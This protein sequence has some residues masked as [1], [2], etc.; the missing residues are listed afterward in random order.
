MTE[1]YHHGD[2]RAALLREAMQTLEAGEPFSL[3]GLA[4][5]VGVSRTAPYRHFAD[6]E[7]LE[8]ALAAQGLRDL[9]DR[10]RP[11]KGGPRDAADLAELGVRYVRFAL[12]RPALF[13]LMF[14]REC[15]VGNP[16]RVEVSAE[17]HAAMGAALRQVFPTRDAEALAAGC[18]GMAHGLA[19]LHLDGKLATSSQEEVEARVRAAFVAMLGG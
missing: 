19:A 14:G 17:I 3:R 9:Q 12:E 5:R 18:W 13:R 10:L 2:L 16:E 15:D 6:R 4:R 11:G 8:S 7:A 1:P